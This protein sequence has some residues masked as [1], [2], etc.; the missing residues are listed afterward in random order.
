LIETLNSG[1]AAP[2]QPAIINVMVGATNLGRAVIDDLGF[3]V[4]S[5]GKTIQLVRA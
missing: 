5:G 3:G 2:A 4:S 1:Q